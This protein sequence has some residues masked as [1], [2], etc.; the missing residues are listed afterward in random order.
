ML[1]GH[2]KPD[3]MLH[4][5]HF[6]ELCAF[7]RSR[8]DREGFDEQWFEAGPLRVKLLFE[9]ACSD[10]EIGMAF[11]PAEKTNGTSVC[12]LDPQPHAGLTVYVLQWSAGHVDQAL[13]PFLTDNKKTLQQLSSSDYTQQFVIRDEEHQMLKVFDQKNG[14]GLLAFRERDLLPPWELFSPLKEFIHLYA[15]KHSC[16]LLHAA[17]LVWPDQ[18]DQGVLL[19]GP[20]GSGK[21]TL[22][23]Y[24]VE[25]GM[26]TN[27]DDY[28]LVDLR[29]DTPQCWSIYRTIKLHPSS[30]VLRGKYRWHTWRSDRLTGKSVML[31]DT[32][33]QGGA[34]LPQVALARVCGVSLK[35][36]LVVHNPKAHSILSDPYRHPYLH[37]CMSTIQQIPYRIDV[38]LALAKQ[39][40]Q[41]IPYEAHTIEPGIEGLQHALVALEGRRT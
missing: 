37:S 21:S 11:R 4:A 34:L 24:G 33:I 15:H 25:Q 7:L 16:V 38:T 19:V 6:D 22:T 14:I 9:Q 26:L 5:C 1:A 17:S 31:A 28:V 18:P 27:G 12:A 35:P 32:V 36:S 2:T 40:H 13:K 23:A 39:L 29:D 10:L 30:P 8:A 3:S 41:S 20:G